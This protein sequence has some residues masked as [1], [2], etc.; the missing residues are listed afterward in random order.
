M[1]LKMSHLESLKEKQLKLQEKQRQEQENLKQQI[2]T[3]E[4]RLEELRKEKEAKAV[5]KAE[6]K[7]QSHERCKSG[8]AKNKTFF[9]VYQEV[10]D[11]LGS[12][13]VTAMTEEGKPGYYNDFIKQI[14]VIVAA[15]EPGIK[16]KVKVEDVLNL[17]WDPDCHL[18]IGK[19]DQKVEEKEDKEYDRLNIRWTFKPEDLTEE[20]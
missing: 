12:E 10:M 5:R 15:V 9:P 19:E 20:V 6:K 7:A 3:E 2:T 4:Q 18:L 13:F 17:V 11:C 16:Q 8:G 14:I 1:P